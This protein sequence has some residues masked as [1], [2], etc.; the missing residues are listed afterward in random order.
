MPIAW[1]FEN[2]L[3]IV[4]TQIN[5][6]FNLFNLYSIVQIHIYTYTYVYTYVQQ[7]I[8]VCMCVHIYIYI[9]RVAVH[10]MDLKDFGGLDFFK[11]PPI[12]H[13]ERNCDL[14]Q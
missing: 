10:I 12:S 7:Y 2:I 1:E 5:L 11:M 3:P 13:L 6:G 9:Y 14:N 8:I 4:A